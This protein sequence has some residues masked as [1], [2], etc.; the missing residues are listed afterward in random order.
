MYD[1]S[2]SKRKRNKYVDYILLIPKW[3]NFDYT[4]LH[5]TKSQNTLQIVTSAVYGNFKCLSMKSYE[6][7]IMILYKVKLRLK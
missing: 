4:F 1:Y 5:E 6:N 2:K 7:M 3:R